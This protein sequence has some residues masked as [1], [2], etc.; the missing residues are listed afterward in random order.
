MTLPPLDSQKPPHDA[1]F[2][3]ILQIMSD[4]SDLLFGPFVIGRPRYL[5]RSHWV[6]PLNPKAFEIHVSS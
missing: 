2:D 3:F 1:I 6:R 5:N 4:Q